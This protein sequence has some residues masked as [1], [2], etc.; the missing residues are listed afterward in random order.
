[1]SVWPEEQLSERVRAA[2]G[3]VRSAVPDLLAAFG[4]RRFTQR[5]CRNIE[6]ALTDVGLEAT[7]PLSKAGPSG[8][9]IISPRPEG[10]PAPVPPEDPVERQSDAQVPRVAVDAANRSL[11]RAAVWSQANLDPRLAAPLA[12]AIAFLAVIVIL[13]S[14]GGH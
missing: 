11:E 8:H 5:A 10:A 1:M 2:G 12:L 6:R 4:V 13:M 9:V 14:S 7:P 3:S